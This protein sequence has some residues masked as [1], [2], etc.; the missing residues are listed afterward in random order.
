MKILQLIIKQN[1]FNEIIAGTKTHEFRE[2]RP[3]T[4][5]KYC[6]VDSDG[7]VEEIDGIIQPRKYDAIQFYVGY[8]PD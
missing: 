7:F 5:R 4:M 6:K 3:N 8:N 1:Y 2:I